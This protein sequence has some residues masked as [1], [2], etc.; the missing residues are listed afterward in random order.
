MMLQEVAQGYGKLQEVT[1]GYIINKVDYMR[2]Y[3]SL[4]IIANTLKPLQGEGVRERDAN[5]FVVA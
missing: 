3:V 5:C 4:L 2:L 1:L